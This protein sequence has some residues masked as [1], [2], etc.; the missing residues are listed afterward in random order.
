MPEITIERLNRSH[1]KDLQFLYKHCFG[2]NVPIGFFEKKLNTTFW[3]ID[4]LGY[5]AYTKDRF[6]ISSYSLFPCKITYQ[7][8]FYFA[9]ISGDSMTHID[10][11]GKGWFDTLGRKTYQL[12]KE[13]DIKLLYGFPNQNSHRN[14]AKMGWIYSDEKT[15]TFILKS[16]TIPFSKFFRKFNSISFLYQ[17]YSQLILSFYKTGEPQFENSLSGNEFG[18]VVHDKD[19]FN[20]KTYTKKHVITLDDCKVWIRADGELKV[21]DI[22]KR[23][24]INFDKLLKKLKFISQLLGCTEI[25]FTVSK[26]SIFYE[27]LKARLKG[28]ESFYVG[29]Y[30]LGLEFEM[31]KVKFTMA[32]FDTF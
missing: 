30:D 10:Y 27:A 25:H 2:K 22:E 31:S 26:E 8:K 11:R 4:H 7:N 28:I 13:S 18:Y 15:S 24:D 14:S 32:D 16:Q 23:S 20:Y 29:R 19:Y 17:W 12:A 5:I 3:G 1:Y 9:A 6:P 21:G